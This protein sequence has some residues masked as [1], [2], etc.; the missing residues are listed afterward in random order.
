[1]NSEPGHKQ[2]VGWIQRVLVQEDNS[3]EKHMGDV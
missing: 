2:Q 3:D 1:M